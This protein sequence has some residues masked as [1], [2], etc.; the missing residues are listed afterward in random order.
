MIQINQN[1]PTSSSAVDT[2]RIDGQGKYWI[3]ELP[4]PNALK[5]VKNLKLTFRWSEYNWHKL[6]DTSASAAVAYLLPCPCAYEDVTFQKVYEAGGFDYSKQLFIDTPADPPKLPYEAVL[7]LSAMSDSD[8]LRSFFDSGC[9]AIRGGT[10]YSQASA[11][12]SNVYIVY[13]YTDAIPYPTNMSPST[14]VIDE[15][16]DN[17]ISW[18]IGFS[19]FVGSNLCQNG[20]KFEWKLKG[21]DDTKIRAVNL[22]GETKSY[23]IPSNTIKDGD[24]FLYRLTLTSNAGITGEISPW[25]ELGTQ[26][27]E[28][29]QCRTLAPVGTYVDGSLPVTFRW[30]H[31]SSINGKS[32]GYDIQFKRSGQWVTVKTDVKTEERTCTV[33]VSE[34]SA[35]VNSWRARTYNSDGI[36]GYWSEPAAFYVVAVPDTPKISSVQSG[37]PRPIVKWT[38][39]GQTGWQL[40][41]VQGNNV[42]YDSGMTAGTGTQAQ[43][44]DYLDDGTYIIRLRI[45]NEFNKISEWALYNHTIKTTKPSKPTFVGMSI[46]DVGIK[47]MLTYTLKNGE[48][49]KVKRDGKIIGNIENEYYDYSA[50]GTCTYS[51]IVI[52]SNDCFS[53][54]DKL[55]L[56]YSIKDVQ[57]SLAGD[58]SQS[59]HLNMQRGTGQPILSAADKYDSA[60][61]Y[62]A[63]R[64]YPCIEFS[65]HTDSSITLKFAFKNWDDYKKMLE[66]FGR[67]E[68]L[69]YR[70]KTGNRFYCVV[71]DISYEIFSYVIDFSI[72]LQRV[73]YYGGD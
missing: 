21:E 31:I 30:E 55:T 14:G 5:A 71:T 66:L 35:G 59:V 43:V 72:T 26:E 51:V 47:L 49:A 25:I 8:R 23:T 16:S 33:D 24:I 44:A 1:N 54:S 22:S 32:T 28:P 38:S 53:E 58:L 11:T 41:V 45:Q 46:E 13:E 48:T 73:D 60:A 3:I 42:I 39:K 56:T 20:A 36:V 7:N 65:E 12:I 68:A 29:P 61:N 17:K 57:L 15:K 37:R 9:F 6:S 69:L 52:N 4:K 67:H 10:E 18:D 63:G 2:I 40:Q 19:G 62:Y 64:S 27:T 34:L 50:L 70:D